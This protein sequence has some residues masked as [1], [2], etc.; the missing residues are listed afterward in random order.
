M[1]RLLTTI[2]L[3]AGFLGV[4]LQ[5]TW[6]VPRQLLGAPL[7]FLPPLIVFAAFRTDVATVSLLATLGG[8][9]TDALS[10]N[11]LGVTVLPLLWI[12]LALHRW[13]EL[14]LQE[15]GYAR[16]VVGMFASAAAPLLT[17][18]IVLTLGEG[19]AIGWD[20]LWKWLVVAVTGGG[21]TPLCFFLLDAAHERL[22]AHPSKP[23][24]FRPDRE[25][26]RGRN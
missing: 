20:S 4:F 19:V 22:A 26:K 18:L 7:N 13:R 2:L 17:L 14:I 10:A 12:G 25:I 6:V 11:A 15:L 16:F 8:L 5:A 23:P 3:I 9:L 21:L 1:N 24:S